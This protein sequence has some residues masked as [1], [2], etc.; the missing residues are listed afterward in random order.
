MQSI[1]SFI[2][3]LSRVLSLVVAMTPVVFAAD[4]ACGV[5]CAKFMLDTYGV[6][7]TFEELVEELLP[8]GRQRS[9]GTTLQEIRDSMSARGLEVSV[10]KVSGFSELPTPSIVHLRPDSTNSVGHFVVCTKVSNDSAEIWDG[11]A[12]D[13][14]LRAEKLQKA[15][16]GYCIADASAMSDVKYRSSFTRFGLV[17]ALAL[18]ATIVLL[19]YSRKGRGRHHFW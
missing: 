10:Y 15:M 17:V 2:G 5:R 4:T 16:S 3:H 11:L 9:S 12:G 19:R 13:Q 14:K 7:A 1:L 6:P 18:V 8:A